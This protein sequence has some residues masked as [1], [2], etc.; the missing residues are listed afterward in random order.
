MSY[1]DMLSEAIFKED[2]DGN[3]IFY[4]WGVMGRGVI[5][6]TKERK[7]KIASF[8]SKY[9]IVTFIMLFVM[10]SLIFFLYAYIFQIMILFVGIAIIMTLWYLKKIDSLI[11][12]L[13]YSLV[14][15]SM[16]DG[17]QK[18]AHK[19]PKQMIWGGFIMML[20]LI[21]F[22]IASLIYLDSSVRWA[23]IILLIAGIFGA[24]AY[25]RMIALSKN[26]QSAQPIRAVS[27]D[28]P[29]AKSIE[30]NFKNI[31][32]VSLLLVVVV[33]SVYYVYADSKRSFDERMAKYKQ[34]TTQ[35]MALYLADLNAK[36][37]QIDPITRHAGAEAK[38]STIYFYRELQSNILS[39][40]IVDVDNIDHE[41]TKM[42][43]QLKREMCGSATYDLFY[44]KGGE[45]FYVYHQVKNRKKIFLFDVKIDKVFCLD[46]TP[47]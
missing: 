12:G 20:M 33:G 21:V 7:E 4:K 3:T 44:D 40:L 23:G 17:W 42:S 37:E 31:S 36:A 8:V 15:L 32:I 41:K 24:Y 26:E 45:L 16:E 1:F 47:R 10:Q 25:Y 28:K 30:W 14:Q 6:D 35:E 18:I 34:M 2:K 39:D 22:S 38:D 5:L 19:V 43:R 27:V 11:Y 46:S 13:E 9:Y 29:S